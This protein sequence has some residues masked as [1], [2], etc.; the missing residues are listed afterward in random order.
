[1]DGYEKWNWHYGAILV[2]GRADDGDYVMVL[3]IL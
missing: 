3:D 2:F 1:M